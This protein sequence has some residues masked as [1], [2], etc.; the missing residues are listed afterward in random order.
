[1]EDPKEDIE[2]A[3]AVSFSEL[4]A[5]NFVRTTAKGPDERYKCLNCG[6]CDIKK[7]GSNGNLMKHCSNSTCF[8][9]RYVG[10]M[11]PRCQIE[12]QPMYRAYWATRKKDVKM[13]DDFFRRVSPKARQM[14]TW[15][16][17]VTKCNMATKVCE[18][19]IMRKHV[20]EK[21][22]SRKTLRKYLIKLADI[23]GL[24]ISDQIGPGNCVADGWSCAGIHYF[25]IY[26]QWPALGLDGKTIEVKRALLS[27]APFISETSL[28]ARNQA[29][30]ILSTYTL[31][32]SP[33]HLIVCLTL[34]NT[35]TNLATARLLK[36]PMVGAYCHRLNLA[37]RHWLSDAFSGTLMGRLQVINAIMLRAS[38][39]KGRGR[40]KEFTT[41][42]PSIQNKTRWTGYQDMAL[43]YEKIHS[44]LEETGLCSPD[45]DEDDDEGEVVEIQED[46][47][48]KTVKIRPILLS[49]SS[50]SDFK[51]NMLPA[52]E[53]L[54]L[55]FKVIQTDLDLSGARECF[56]S[57]KNHPI[58]KG[59]SPEYERRLLPNHKLVVSPH[60]ET[61][62]CK[63]IE[64]NNED[65]TQEEKIACEILLK[66][67]WKSLYKKSPPEDRSE[68]DE[69]ARYGQYSPSKF[70]KDAKRRRKP[71]GTVV[72]NRYLSNLSWVSPTTVIV[73]RLFS[74]NRHILTF[75][76]RRMLPRVFEA[77]IFLKENQHLWDASLIQDMMAGLW[78]SRLKQEYDEEQLNNDEIDELETQSS[79]GL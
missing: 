37:S 34:D 17:L 75:A 74:K 46:G 13:V 67:N 71:V 16:E 78:D 10:A 53:K 70:F 23:V 15:I 26:H 19:P 58:L 50:L 45:S 47:C 3:P 39:L 62:V 12:L 64:G 5:W 18:D 7:S 38:T 41:Y 29:D 33:S 63:I 1:M 11:D 42:V 8:G 30:S 24:V 43:K 56:H 14:E 4:V 77:I 32:G 9:F 35:N 40:L 28:D 57:A 66:S 51:Q 31:Y 59:H 20:K 65:M 21:G 68:S 69:E 44:A 79:V 60:F 27:C 72:E 22:I 48:V 2:L 52:M 25:A 55:F 49:G 61:G 36:K 73:E 76:R 54:R 6:S